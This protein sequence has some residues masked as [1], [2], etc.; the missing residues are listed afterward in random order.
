M[1]GRINRKTCLPPQAHDLM[2]VIKP[3]AFLFEADDPQTTHSAQG[4]L[5]AV[6]SLLAVIQGSRLPRIPQL[7]RDR[8]LHLH[9]M[10][11][12]LLD[13][14]SITE[15]DDEAKYIYTYL[16]EVV[17]TP[18]GRRQRAPLPGHVH[19]L[20]N[21]QDSYAYG[22]LRQ[23]MQDPEVHARVQRAVKALGS[24]A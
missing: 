15:D 19:S 22:V 24:S 7:R 2:H 23:L 21:M 20:M 3:A 16:V 8:E 9:E 18:R 13:W 5:K 6:E 17:G 4:A 12:H 14:L 11:T 1:M 10:L